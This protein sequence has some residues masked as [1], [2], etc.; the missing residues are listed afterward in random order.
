M[1]LHNDMR[2]FDRAR[3]MDA[4]KRIWREIGWVTDRDDAL[5]MEDFYS[6]GRTLTGVVDD[7]A[8]CAV[9]TMPGTILLD[10]TELE[11]C[12]VTAV[13]TGRVGRKRGFAK[14][15]TAVQLAES[16][17]EGAE[18]A[19]LGMFEQGFYD[20]VGFGRSTY[21]HIFS[22]DPATLLVDTP[23]RS[24]KRVTEDDWR[25][26]H[27]S[28]GA[29]LRSHGGCMI[30]PAEFI[31]AET[32]WTSNGF[33][34]GYYDGDALTHFIWCSTDEP[35]HGPVRV[36]MMAYQTPEQLMELL[37]VL[38]SLGDQIRSV[39]MVE[40]AHVRLQ[41]WLE[42]PFRNRGISKNSPHQA[43]H[44]AP[45]WW[46]LRIMDVPAC[47]AAL[48]VHAPVPRFRVDLHDPAADVLAGSWQ[49]VS[50]SYTL[51][52]AERSHAAVE[53]ADGLPVLKA[54]VNALTRLLFGIAPASVLALA[55]DFEAPPE[56]IRALDRAIRLPD[57]RPG[58][59]F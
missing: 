2:W 4:I 5:G 47:V 25:S 51:D 30:R 28:L 40:P 15:L 27:R 21:Q 33:G 22:F 45:S 29:R 1:Q 56:L 43:D 32:T 13:T 12:A 17:E 35:E 19:A 11:L 48:T 54:S 24:P 16:M 36:D 31:A 44:R 10:E 3:D 23:S 58:L 41:D 8:E 53:A 50:G 20:L 59:E 49:G 38:K 26:M 39:R 52:L 14:R 57:A 6:V 7:E 37:G 55:V 18:V 42:Q 46:Q 9:Q 34:L